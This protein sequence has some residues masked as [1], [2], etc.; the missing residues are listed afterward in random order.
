MDQFLIK[1]WELLVIL[2]IVLV[3][4]A[5]THHQFNKIIKELDFIKFNL[6][7]CGLV[8]EKS[9]ECEVNVSPSQIKTIENIKK[10]KFFLNQIKIMEMDK[11]S[12]E[13]TEKFLD[14]EIDYLERDLIKS[15]GAKEYEKLKN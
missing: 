1:H 14:S 3:F 8:K 6:T 10:I 5:W 15:L 4:I 12:Q 11:Y 9:N 13:R 7:T 2:F